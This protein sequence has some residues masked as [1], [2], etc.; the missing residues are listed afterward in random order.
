MLR[1]HDKNSHA[2]AYVL[3]ILAQLVADNIVPKAMLIVMLRAG[4]DR[5][6]DT[7]VNTRKRAVL[8]IYSVLKVY[9]FIYSRDSNF[10]TQEE[11]RKDIDDLTEEEATHRRNLERLN[12]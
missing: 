3:N 4:V 1:I 12:E 6:K 9:Q 7:S 11:L 5:L 2:R 10:R 8:L